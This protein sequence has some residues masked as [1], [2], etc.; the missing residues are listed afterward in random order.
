MGFKLKTKNLPLRAPCKDKYCY[1]LKNSGTCLRDCS[2]TFPHICQHCQGKH[3][4][5]DCTRPRQNPRT[6]Q[7]NLPTTVISTLIQV[8]PLENF[9]TAC[10]AEAKLFS[11]RRFTFG[12][13]FSYT[14]DC[15]CH[16]SKKFVSSWSRDCYSNG[17]LT[18]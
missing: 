4:K 13:P 15:C 11:L 1:V 3:S 7:H 17:A 12:F 9:L 18:R 8:Q 2:C 10:D 16:L 14:G 5:Q 6:K